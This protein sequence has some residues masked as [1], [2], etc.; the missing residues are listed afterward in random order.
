MLDNYHAL[1]SICLLTHTRIHPLAYTIYIY[2][3]KPLPTQPVNI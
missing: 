2:K 1:L 3:L